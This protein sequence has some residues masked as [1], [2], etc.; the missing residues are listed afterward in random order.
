LAEH[1]VTDA[2]ADSLRRWLTET[3]GDGTVVLRGMGL[4]LLDTRAA[5]LEKLDECFVLVED[6]WDGNSRS[7]GQLVIDVR[8]LLA[9]VHGEEPAIGD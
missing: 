9:E 6:E 8:A 7:E 5:F 1:L 4:R 2:E 3:W